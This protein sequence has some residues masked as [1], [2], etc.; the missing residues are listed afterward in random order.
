MKLTFALFILI[1]VAS[2]STR[3]QRMQGSVAMKLSDT[4]AHVCLGEGQVSVGDR[5]TLFRNDCV[6]KKVCEKVP[7]GQ[8][9][10]TKNLNEHYSEVTLTNPAKFSEGNFVEMAR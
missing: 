4:V 3:H 8:G 5:V 9:K 7:V 2:C 6:G 10:I 1:A